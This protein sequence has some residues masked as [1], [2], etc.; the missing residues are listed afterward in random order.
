MN[1]INISAGGGGV[2]ARVR[3]KEDRREPRIYRA[4]DGIV[5]GQIIPQHVINGMLQN[6]LIAY[7]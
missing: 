6:I 5:C 2:A 7:Y 1:I 4:P 3:Q